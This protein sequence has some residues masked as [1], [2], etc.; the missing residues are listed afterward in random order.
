MPP[1]C[2]PFPP[3]CLAVIASVVDLVITVQFRT[4]RGADVREMS[5]GSVLADVGGGG[6]STTKLVCL[7]VL[8]GFTLLTNLAAA[9]VILFRRTRQDCTTT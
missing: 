2:Q 4:V 7:S 1:N 8:L 6:G 5:E 9:P 3:S